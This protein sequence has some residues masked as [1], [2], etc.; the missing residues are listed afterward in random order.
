[1]LCLQN[2]MFAVAWIVLTWR[3]VPSARTTFKIQRGRATMASAR[4]TLPDKEIGNCEDGKVINGPFYRPMYFYPLIIAIVDTPPF[5]RLKDIKQLGRTSYI[6]T[7]R[8]HSRF[9]HSLGTCHITRLIVK[10]LR[11][12]TKI[13][14][15]D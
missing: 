14:K 10:I 3:E 13:W 9:D 5:Q 6:Y 12:E 8:V 4:A 11:K 1:M 15:S 2:E 7:G